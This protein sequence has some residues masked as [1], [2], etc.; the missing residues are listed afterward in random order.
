MSAGNTKLISKSALNH[1]F[2][3]N[4]F[5]TFLAARQAMLDNPQTAMREDLINRL[6]EWIERKPDIVNLVEG[7]EAAL[8]PRQLL[9]QLPLD[10]LPEDYKSWLRP[11]IHELYCARTGIRE[12]V[13]ALKVKIEAVDNLVTAIIKGQGTKDAGKRLYQACRELSEGISSLPSQIQV[14]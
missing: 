7:M 12:K 2:L 9:Y 1:D 6:D 4:R 3:Q 8:S 10:S 14:I 13:D 11:L 5:L